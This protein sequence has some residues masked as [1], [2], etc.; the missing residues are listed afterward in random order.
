MK[1]RLKFLPPPEKPAPVTTLKSGFAFPGPSDRLTINGMTGSGKTTFAFW[2][3]AES[4]DFNVK[5]WVFI[6]FKGEE[7]LNSAIADK[8]VEEL[9]LKDLPKGPGAFVVRP[10]PRT[11]LPVLIAWLWQ[12]YERGH[13]G[14]FLDEATMIPELRGELNSGG[15]YQSLLSQ[16]RSKIIPVWTLAQR[17]AFVNK[18]IYSES[19][20]S[21]AF[22]LKNGEDEKK[23]IREAISD[24]SENFDRVWGAN[25]NNLHSPEF[26]HWSRWYDANQGLSLNLR[27]CPPAKDILDLLFDRVDNLKQRRSI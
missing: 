18:M 3:F 8:S 11:D 6:D 23:L 2:L 10:N 9:G 21:C 24:K 27:P 4:A 13:V 5:P 14:L 17:P 25:A 20:F 22:K 15:P 12:V 26:A 19:N 7:L 16:G 1:E